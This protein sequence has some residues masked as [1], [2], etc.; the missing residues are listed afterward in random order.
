MDSKQYIETNK[1]RFLEE[2]FE[3]FVNAVKGLSS[4]EKDDLIA[5]AT[6]TYFNIDK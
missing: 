3:E 6:M 1:D 4:D 5:K 2:L